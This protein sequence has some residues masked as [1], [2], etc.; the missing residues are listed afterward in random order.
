MAPERG[1]G[2]R[3]EAR[4]MKKEERPRITVAYGS[5]QGCP[6]PKGVILR[7]S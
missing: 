6:A 4:R 5:M 2:E 1:R 3:L 7:T